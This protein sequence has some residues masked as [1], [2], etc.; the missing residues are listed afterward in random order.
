MDQTRYGQNSMTQ[1]QYDQ[2]SLTQQSGLNKALQAVMAQ[3]DN[4]DFKI[5]NF[6]INYN[7]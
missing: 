6:V 5:E 1:P 4:N 7:L 3:F 2:H